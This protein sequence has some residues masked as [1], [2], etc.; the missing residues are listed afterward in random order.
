[1]YAGITRPGV[2]LCAPFERAPI[3]IHPSLLRFDAPHCV[4]CMPV[5]DRYEQEE[6]AAKALEA[7]KLRKQA[8]KA[9]LAAAERKEVAAARQRQDPL[10]STCLQC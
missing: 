10:G 8:E 9:R 4:H 5:R 2:L 3:L 6:K 1:M 7:E